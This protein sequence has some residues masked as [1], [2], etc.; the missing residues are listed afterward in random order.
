[1]IRPEDDSFHP[2]LDTSNDPY[3]NESSWF[4]VLIPKLKI[5]G[6]Y[7]FYHRPNMNLSSGGFGL[8]DP[9]GD[10]IATCLYHD[11]D[12]QQALP[13]GADMF[14]FSLRG[15]RGLTV[16]LI[17]PLKKYHLVYAGDGCDVDLIW[18]AIQAPVEQRHP[19]PDFDKRRAAAADPD[20]VNPSMVTWGPAHYEHFGRMRGR[21]DIDGQVFN[22]DDWSV[23]DRSWGP[24]QDDQSRDRFLR[25]SLVYAVA[26]EDSYFN[27]MTNSHLDKN[28]DPILGTTEPLSWGYYARDG[29]TAYLVDGESRVERGSNGRP[30]QVHIQATDEIGRTF[31]AVGR[32]NNTLKWS[33]YP[34]FFAWWSAA[35]WDFDTATAA[36]GE[37]IDWMTARQNRRLQR[38]VKSPSASKR[39]TALRR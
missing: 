9:S 39:E 6:F 34:S 21:I 8:W 29:K 17:E 2:D 13:S 31:E 12:T 1:M 10:E 26:S 24:R 23:H 15:G 35:E 28:D 32:A 25:S 19:E 30:L 18:E 14:N 11:W 37:I 22:V 7:Y 16:E 4:S 36:S 38:A 27:L 20:V 33:N 3:W 5:S